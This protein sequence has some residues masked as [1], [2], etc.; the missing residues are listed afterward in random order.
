MQKTK[1]PSD[2]IHM[3]W[4][5]IAIFAVSFISFSCALDLEKFAEVKTNHV[6]LKDVSAEKQARFRS[7]LKNLNTVELQIYV[8][9]EKLSQLQQ[10][11]PVDVGC[12]RYHN[13]H[14]KEGGFRVPTL[15]D[16]HNARLS[17]L[18][19]RLGLLTMFRDQILEVLNSNK[20]SA[21]IEFP[22]LQE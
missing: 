6:G 19:I 17:R 5:S 20:Y 18:Y 21:V 13:I 15:C 7:L 1:L 3:L 14:L 16:I 11:D 2:F 9:Q 10:I 22:H 4:A 12:R 8:A